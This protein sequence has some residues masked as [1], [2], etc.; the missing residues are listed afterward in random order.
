M[1]K[2]R[3]II[4]ILITF[5]LVGCGSK[6]EITSSEF[7]EI[8]RD[9]DFYIQDVKEQFSEYDYIKEAMIAVKSGKYQIEFYVLEDEENALAF[10]K[11]NKDVF[12]ASKEST[13]LYA[14]VDFEHNNRYTLTT[15]NEYKVISRI[16]KTV[17]YVNTTK[18]NKNDVNKVLKKLGY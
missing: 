1:K 11:Y 10:Y 2:L 6:K 9:N 14:E 7:K 4:L 5:L 3:N 13:S 18:E 15:G 12:E 16:N 8:T 17:V